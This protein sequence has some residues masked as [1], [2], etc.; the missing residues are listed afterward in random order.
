LIASYDIDEHTRL[1]RV[2]VDPDMAKLYAAGWTAI[3]WRRRQE[4][5]GKPLAL[6]LHGY[7]SSHAKPLPVKVGTLR[8]LSGSKTAA[9]FKFRQQLRK[10]LDELKAIGAIASW[11][12]DAADLVTVDR[13][14]AI[15]ASQRRHVIKAKSRRKR[16]E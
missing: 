4:L 5:R 10:A 12:I 13:G 1:Y 2:C 8:N 7:Y 6:W 16:K 15:T 11:Q 3:D 14:D 9:L